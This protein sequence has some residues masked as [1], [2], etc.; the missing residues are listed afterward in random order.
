MGPQA[1]KTK[2]TIALCMIVKNES[3]VLGRALNSVKEFVDYFVICDTGSTDGTPEIA[4]EY[5][6]K[7]NLKGEVHSR[8]WV[9]FSHNRNEAFSYAEG[10]ADYF[11]TLDADEVVAPLINGVPDLQKKV[12]G[13]PDITADRVEV[14]THYGSIVYSRGMLFKQGKDFKWTWP[15]H[16]VCGSLK[17]KSVQSIGDVCVYPT[18]EGARAK[19]DKRFLRDA[20]VFEE[21]LLEK[22][23]DARAWFYLAQSYRD[24]GEVKKALEPLRKCLEFTMWDEERFMATLR[25]AQYRQTAGDPFESVVGQYL[26]AYET[27]PTRAEPLFELMTQYM[28]KKMYHA[29]TLVGETAVKIPYPTDDILFIS[30][31]L[32]SWKIAD[33]LSVCYHWVGRYKESYELAKTLLKNPDIG[34]EDLKR[35]RKNI[36]SSKEKLD[37]N[38]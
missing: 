27:R 37:G 3:K 29:A 15:V 22:P 36:K 6:K 5:F 21:W 4:T 23:T 25:L 18:A 8:P 32:Y 1:S 28:S 13:L 34:K 20:Y 7:Y 17:Q 19:D 26:K 35:I 38:G 2:K 16:E 33:E 30:K 10:K 9:N 12:V 24:G 14:M 31:H 11:M